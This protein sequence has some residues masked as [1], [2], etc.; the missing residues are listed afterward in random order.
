MGF[1]GPKFTWQRGQAQARLD[2]FLCNSYWDEAHPDSSVLHLL[3]KRSDHRPLLLRVGLSPAGHSKSPFRYF[4]AL[5]YSCFWFDRLQET[6]CDGT[7]KRNAARSLQPSFFFLQHLE[8]E[9]LLELEELLDYEE[10]LWRQK[11][12]SDWIH[13]G[14]RNTSY[15]HRKA[16][17]RK[18]RNRIS[19][20]KIGDGSWC[21]DEETLKD[22][23]VAYYKSL[24]SLDQREVHPS[25]YHSSFPDIDS[26]S[27]SHLDSVP[28]STE[29]HASLM[30]M[31]PL[32]APAY[33]PVLSPG[34]AIIAMSL[35][36]PMSASQF[37]M[38]RFP[39]GQ[40][41]LH[42]GSALIQMEQF[43][44]IPAM[45]GQAV[46]Y[47]TVMVLGLLVL[48][49]FVQVQSDCLKAISE[50][51]DTSAAHGFSILLRDILSL[52]QHNWVIQFLWVPR[53]ANTVADHLLKQIPRTHF[54]M[55][56][57]DAPPDYIQSLLDRDMNSHHG[58][59]DA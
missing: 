1:S 10:L 28:S 47:V 59:I 29:I 56:H 37:V 9:L 40:P 18:V 46:L 31:A 58:L 25:T 32:K 57:F 53:S 42:L 21:D 22:E 11:S 43:A 26:N 17:L 41:C 35:L 3:R 12:C 8:S 51:S 33:L 14:D 20:L 48:A 36:P 13:L 30:D 45:Q 34:R 52:R 50:L 38:F 27:L 16:K 49:W 2:R 23:A 7:A 55:I 4:T 24:F 19:S 5:E 15:F 44:C 39:D 6:T 54:D